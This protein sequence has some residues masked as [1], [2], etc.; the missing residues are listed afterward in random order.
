MPDLSKVALTFS[1]R[2]LRYRW[3]L[4][5]L[6][7]IMVVVVE[8]E[9][10]MPV[11]FFNPNPDF[12]RETLLFA[13]ILPIVNGLVLSLLART[14]QDRDLAERDLGQQRTLGRQLSKASTWNDIVQTI[15][16]FPH[17]IPLV[18][19]TTLYSQTSEGDYYELIASWTRESVS[20]IYRVPRI[21]K[22]RCTACERSD[23]DSSDSIIPCED[24]DG[25]HTSSLY[26][27]YC[28]PLRSN[29]DIVAILVLYYRTGKIVTTADI[30]SIAGVASEMAL[31]LRSACLQ[32]SVLNQ[33]AVTALERKRIAR[34]LHDTLGQNISYLRLK[35]DQI[36][37]HHDTLNEI[38]AIRQELERMRDIADDAYNQVRHT[39]EELQPVIDL[40]FGQALLEHA[41]T[42]GRRANFKVHLAA[43]GTPSALG[44]RTKRQLLFICRESLNNIEKYAQAA[45][46]NIELNW[47]ATELVVIVSDDGVGFDLSEISTEGH[48]GLRIMQERA[49]EIDGEVAIS[50]IPGEGTQVSVTVPLAAKG[51][52]KKSGPELQGVL[53]D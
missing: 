48:Y 43:R 37:G 29:E 17:E 24:L 22:E 36:S 31:A 9:E 49:D 5:G 38:S 28:I 50:S 25:S 23:I 44:V 30:R 45:N 32:E 27:G 42:I 18:A 13:V 34:N 11:K 51:W 52:V 40:D 6:T 12:I 8:F 1:S 53:E 19:G 16:Q 21:G 2:L 10:H 7:S 46:V 47:L 41:S 39:L 26:S 3:W 20:P 35:L 15:V 4:M 33:A 14:C